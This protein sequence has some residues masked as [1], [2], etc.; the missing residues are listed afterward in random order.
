M[1]S[2]TTKTAARTTTPGVAV[3][4]IGCFREVTLR[5]LLFDSDSSAVN[6]D[7]GSRIDQAIAQY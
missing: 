2:R 6:A 4:E 1:A 3:D 7:D 5:G